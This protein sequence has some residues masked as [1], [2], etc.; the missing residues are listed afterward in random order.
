MVLK[1]DESNHSRQSGHSVNNSN[2][3]MRLRYLVLAYEDGRQLKIPFDLAAL[4]HVHEDND[5]MNN[6]NNKRII[7]KQSSNGVPRVISNSNYLSDSLHAALSDE[8]NKIVS[9][10]LVGG[11]TNN[12]ELENSNQGNTTVPALGLSMIENAIDADHGHSPID[13]IMED[14]TSANLRCLTS[15]DDTLLS[16]NVNTKLIRVG[17]KTQQRIIQ[18]SMS[19]TNSFEFGYKKYKT[20][21]DS[22]RDLHL[23]EHKERELTH[24]TTITSTSHDS[25]IE[26]QIVLSLLFFFVV[27][28]VTT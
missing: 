10:V 8:N 5:N 17:G 16:P 1:H 11:D 21:Q 25:E 26:L 20:R 12:E 23:D 15:D 24:S 22:D 9:A 7:R 18:S 4:N 27:F 3:S 6:K 2:D 14:D 19:F 28:L 13:V